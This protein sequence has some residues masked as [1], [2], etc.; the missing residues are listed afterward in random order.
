MSGDYPGAVKSYRYLS[1][2]Q[3]TNNIAQGLSS[4]IMDNI[5]KVTDCSERLLLHGVSLGAHTCGVAGY[6]LK[7]RGVIV[8]RM[9]GEQSDYGNWKL[10][11]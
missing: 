8:P 6:L 2:A 9:I 11:Y 10:G 7:Q 5:C 1:A 4:Y 3:E